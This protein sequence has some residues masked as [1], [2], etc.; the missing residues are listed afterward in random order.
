[1]KGDL[2]S[3]FVFFEANNKACIDEL[4]TRPSVVPFET[5]GP[6]KVLHARGGFFAKITGD[7]AFLERHGGVK[8]VVHVLSFDVMGGARF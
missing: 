7:L 4:W 3:S 5:Q 8:I 1:M 6:G 2:P